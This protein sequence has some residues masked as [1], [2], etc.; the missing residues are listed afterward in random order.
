MKDVTEADFADEVLASDK[1]VLAHFWAEWCGPCHMLNPTLEEIAAEHGD[2]L[3]I[4]KLNIDSNPTIAQNLQVASLPTL[5]L[6]E[7]GE[8]VKQSVGAKPK[9]V[10]LRDLVDY[11]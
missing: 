4:V 5:V 9:A 7:G 11:I 1:P 10:L 8:A 3:K 2:K 6:F